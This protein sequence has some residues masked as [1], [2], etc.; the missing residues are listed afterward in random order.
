MK[1]GKIGYGAPER[2]GPDQVNAALV[3]LLIADALAHLSA[4]HRA[5]VRRA[6]YLGWTTMQIA[7]DLRIEECTVKSRLHFALRALRLILQRRLTRCTL[8]ASG[9]QRL[10]AGVVPSLQAL[11]AGASDGDRRGAG[12][13]SPAASDIRER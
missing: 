7:D 9:R 10:R 4:E 13:R 2:V 11:L 6:Y 1:R 5:V 3:R 12:R 8:G